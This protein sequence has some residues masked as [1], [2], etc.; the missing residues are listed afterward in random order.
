VD[1]TD[2]LRRR[3]QAQT[4]ALPRESMLRAVDVLAD[5]VAEQRQGSPRLP[6]ELAL[7]QLAVPAAAGGDVADLADRVARLE[8]G[9]AT[10]PPPTPPQPAPPA[11]GAHPVP[12]AGGAR[13]DATAGVPS[14]NR[15]RRRHPSPEPPASPAARADC[16]RAGPGGA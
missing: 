11:A 8:Q 15:P 10:V 7:A 12:R 4:T 6:L 13:P 3:L 5:T 16:A 9:V 1:A 2:E 14:P